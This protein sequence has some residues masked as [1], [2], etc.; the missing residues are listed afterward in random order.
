MLLKNEGDLLPLDLGGD[1]KNV[2]VVGPLADDARSVLGGWAMKGRADEATSILSGLREVL[3]S[4]VNLQYEPGTDVRS[5]DRSGIAAAVTA[6]E[7]AD[8]VVLV[9]GEDWGM[10]SEANNRVS[11]DL[12]G[13]QNELARAIVATGKPVVAV[14]VNGRPLSVQWLDDNVGAIVETWFLGNESGHVVADVLTGSV[15]PSGKLPVTFPRSVGQVPIYYGTRKSGRPH[16]PN[17]QYTLRYIDSPNTP[18]YPFGYGLSYTSFE[19]SDIALDRST[20]SHDG[21]LTISATIANTGSR[22]GTEIVQL[23]TNDPVASVTRPVRELKGFKRLSLSPGE[24]RRVAFTITAMDLAFHDA[25]FNKVA[26][27]GSFNVYIAPS[28]V[29]GLKTSFELDADWRP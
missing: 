6:A 23:Y 14:L 16:V 5:D 19:Y 10:S 3:P 9:V 26:E 24:S 18:L 2:T 27:A 12:P 15:N 21:S 13:T 25:L 29:G 8:V 1:V 20:L 11:L 7:G 17:T 4:N 28:S 22:A